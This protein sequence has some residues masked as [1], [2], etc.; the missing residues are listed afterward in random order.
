MCTSVSHPPPFSLY[1]NDLLQQI[2]DLVVLTLG[3][4]HTKAGIK[5]VLI[6]DPA[7]AHSIS[8]W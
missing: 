4:D 1:L 5:A 2:V 7:R 3:K 6:A 8:P